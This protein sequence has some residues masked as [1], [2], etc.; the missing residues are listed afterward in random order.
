MSQEVFNEGPTTSQHIESRDDSH[1]QSTTF[2]L[3][4]TRSMGLLDNFITPQS[5][6]PCGGN[7]SRS[8][9]EI[10]H[11]CNPTQRSI[12]NSKLTSGSFIPQ[13]S[14]NK[15]N[16][17]KDAA[18]IHVRYRPISL[19]SQPSSLTNNANTSCSHYMNR[20]LKVNSPQS[21]QSDDFSDDYNNS[22]DSVS[23]QSSVSLIPKHQLKRKQQQQHQQHQ[24]R[25]RSDNE[26]NKNADDY[27]DHLHHHQ[28]LTNLLH[29]DIDV[30]DA[31][32]KHVDYLTHK[33]AE[34]EI[35]KSWKYVTLRRSAVADSARLENASWRTWAQTRSNLKTISPE[36]L[37]W[38][39][40]T[41][42]T[43]LYGPV[44]ESQS[45]KLNRNHQNG[46]G[47][48]L[49]F[50]NTNHSSNTDS[51]HSEMTNAGHTNHNNDDK[52]NKVNNNSSRSSS[53]S[54]D[55]NTETDTIRSSHG[56]SGFK[57]T[58]NNANI[59]RNENYSLLSNNN[60]NE[61]NS[62]PNPSGEHLKSILKKKSNVEKMIGGSSYSRLQHLL[63]N[64]ERK[65]SSDDYY[66]SPNLEPTTPIYNQKCSPIDSTSNLSNN[67]S[68]NFSNS[69][70]NSTIT[71]NKVLPMKIKSSLKNSLLNIKEKNDSNQ[72]IGKKEKHIHFNLRVDQCI[73]LEN[74]DDSGVEDLD[75][76]KIPSISKYMDN[77]YE[78]TKSYESDNDDSDGDDEHDDN[79]NGNY[80]NDNED[81]EY[82]YD[83][84]D[85]EGFVLKPTLHSFSGTGDMTTIAPL[86]STVL[87]FASDDEMT[88]PVRHSSSQDRLFTTSHNTK[89]NR[90]YDYYYDYN[91]VYSNNSNPL[92]YSTPNADV[93]MVD[94]PKDFQL[95]AEPEFSQ[96]VS[97][98]TSTTVNTSPD[99]QMYDVPLALQQTRSDSSSYD[100]SSFP[101]SDS[102][103]YFYYD[104]DRFNEGLSLKRSA[105]IGSHHGSSQ[106]VSSI[107]VGLSGL[108]LTST[109]LRAS[110][111][112][113]SKPQLCQMAGLQTSQSNLHSKESG[114]SFGGSQAPKDMK[115]KFIF[116]DSEDSFSDDNRMDVDEIVSAVKSNSSIGSLADINRQFS[117][118]TRRNFGLNNQ[119]K[120]GFS[121]GSDSDSES[122]Q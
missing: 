58:D 62:N 71:S 43:W 54:C 25:Y 94:V 95:G 57:N 23:S 56:G 90:G 22:E 69:N 73:A 47:N 115:R 79:D 108:D 119:A 100:N 37:N 4:R 109:G 2:K 117:G 16:L 36:E 5:S 9:D 78:S 84:D 46:S 107:K 7:S 24:D 110:T 98:S 68:F 77:E 70:S 17:Q 6:T 102:D 39:K 52:T 20:N 53:S 45:I 121:F 30:K 97:P 88:E 29:D 18:P 11:A 12:P 76:D 34:D 38:S 96:S 91:T 93:E 64:R 50:D 112:L 13:E 33:W 31:P 32:D 114:S 41:D 82:D 14:L 61:T 67:L 104:D 1:F 105:S 86:P 65:N 72:S 116:D 106:S 85:D 10:D 55:N 99:Q 28:D 120:S 92:V 101:N 40:D 27:D 81:D 8:R 60:N 80:D 103:G 111:G 15:L 89:T 51:Y 66:S 74:G 118:L 19:P 21:F 113:G 35:S 44:I 63:E 49:N 83:D 59:P 26:K 87:K 122:S 48:S 3:K 42:V 75:N